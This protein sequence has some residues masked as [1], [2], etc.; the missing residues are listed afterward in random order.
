MDNAIHLINPHVK[1]GLVISRVD[2]VSYPFDHPGPYTEERGSCPCFSRC[3][4]KTGETHKIYSIV[5]IA[6]DESF[7]M[8]SASTSEEETEASL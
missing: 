8:S 2:R 4:E 5:F 1:S 7:N 3:P 6:C